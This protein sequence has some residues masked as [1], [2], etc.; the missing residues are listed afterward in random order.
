MMSEATRR[1]LSALAMCLLLAACGR[2]LTGPRAPEPEPPGYSLSVS[3]SSK[4]T[5]KPGEELFLDL[6]IQRETGF[7]GQITF[8]AEA[9]QG[10][11][12]IVQP[13]VIIR[14]D[15]TDLVIVAAHSVARGKHDVV[16]TGMSEG[17]NNRV[18]VVELTV[19]D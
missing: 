3:P 11:V 5:V 7:E 17:L 18:V 9:P 6:L 1:R 15:D 10:I 4:A 13:K 8:S 12:A 14:R 2:E 16:F 19:V